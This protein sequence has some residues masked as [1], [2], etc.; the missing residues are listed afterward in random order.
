MQSKISFKSVVLTAGGALSIVLVLSG[1]IALGIA[2]AVATYVGDPLW[3]R[4]GSENS[5]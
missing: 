3:K 5:H 4:S 1:H 2:T